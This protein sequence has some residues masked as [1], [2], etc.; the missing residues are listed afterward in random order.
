MISTDV[1]ENWID[2]SCGSNVSNTK[3]SCIFGPLASTEICNNAL[4]SLSYYVLHE[5]DDFGTIKSCSAEVIVSDI[6][7]STS[8]SSTM[9]AFGIQYFNSIS[10]YDAAKTNVPANRYLNGTD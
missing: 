5:N 7:Y 3:A 10:A 6:A 1:T 2:N 9:Q 8:G 4:V